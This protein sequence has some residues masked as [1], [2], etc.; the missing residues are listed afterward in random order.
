MNAS[1][2]AFI[3]MSVLLNLLLAGL[4][5]GNVSRGL[6]GHRNYSWDEI[7]MSLSPEKRQHFQDAMHQAEQDTGEL[8]QRLND[9][10]KKAASTLKSEPFHKE[11]YIAQMQQ[12]NQLHGQIMQ[13]MVATVAG[14]AEQLSPEERATLAEMLRRPP[15]PPADD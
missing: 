2:K 5:I 6:M 4:V 8:R 13:R 14:L 1:L 9:A 7:A 10:H 12:V 15:R 3:A 11:A